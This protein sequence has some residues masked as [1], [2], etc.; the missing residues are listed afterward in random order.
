MY[1]LMVVINLKQS[2]LYSKAVNYDKLCSIGIVKD[3][4]T[5]ISKL[6]ADKEFEFVVKRGATRH[7]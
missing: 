6:P 3:N 1:I 5:N 2:T 4:Q 7:Q